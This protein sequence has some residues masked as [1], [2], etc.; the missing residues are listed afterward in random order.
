[1]N[2]VFRKSLLMTSSL[3]EEKKERQHVGRRY[4]AVTHVTFHTR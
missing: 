2:P 3:S 4:A 1:M